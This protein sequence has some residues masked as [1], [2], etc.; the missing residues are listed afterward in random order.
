M[1][2][3]NK[4]IPNRSKSQVCHIE[5]LTNMIKKRCHKNRYSIVE[6]ETCFVKVRSRYRKQNEER[7]RR[8][9]RGFT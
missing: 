6:R 2:D 4:L 9:E 5:S 7:L 1:I 8:K 3:T